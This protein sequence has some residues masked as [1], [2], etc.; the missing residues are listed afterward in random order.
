MDLSDALSNQQSTPTW[1]GGQGIGAWPNQ[2]NQLPQPS[3]P[4]QPGQPT[5]P[6]WPGQ[7]GQPTQPSWPGQPGQ[8]GQPSWPGQPGQ[9]TQP[10][11][12][13]QPTQPTQPSQPSWPGQPTQPPQPA[14]PG[15]PSQP[16]Q[17]GQP[18]QPTKP[19]WP[20]QPSQPTHPGWPSPSPQSLVVPYSQRL[21][22]GVYDKLL[23]TIAGIIKPNADK[24]T[25]DLCTPQGQAFHFNP[26]FNEGGRKVIVRNSCID[27][28]WGREERELSNFP[29]VQ[30]QPFEIKIMCSSSEYK[31]A[32][33]NNHLLTFQHRVR[34]LRSICNLNVCYDLTLTTVNMETVN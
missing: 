28:K 19:G 24:I 33:N 8:P 15:Q 25:V 21:P 11:W 29:F 34:D 17:P 3:W 10:S 20:S 22:N 27:T 6:S 18:S 9:P 12:P 30:G 31:V 23:I 16:G 4:G 5:Q 13:G 32:V 7:P 14:W 26:R 2:P 1:P